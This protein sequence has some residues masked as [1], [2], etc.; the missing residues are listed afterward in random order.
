MHQVQGAQTLPLYLTKEHKEYFTTNEL[1]LGPARLS[2]KPLTERP[3]FNPFSSDNTTP[4][5]NF[6][7]SPEINGSK[8]DL[9]R[10][11]DEIIQ[12]EATYISNCSNLVIMYLGHLQHLQFEL[13]AA[14]HITKECILALVTIHQRLLDEMNNIRSKN[15]SIVDQCNQIAKSIAKSGIS[16]FW[17]SLYCTHYD[18]LIP[19][20]PLAKSNSKN[21]PLMKSFLLGM[22]N[23]L[24]SQHAKHK[25][26]SFMSLCQRPVDRIVKYKLFIKGMMNTFIE[27][28]KDTFNLEKAYEL[29]SQQLSKIDDSR[30]SMNANRQLNN[31]VN[32]ESLCDVDANFFGNPVSV[33][34]ASVIYVKNSKPEMNHSPIV[35]Y[36]AHLVILEYNQVINRHSMGKYKPKFIIPLL[37]TSMVKEFRY[38]LHVNLSTNIKL[39]FRSSSNQYQVVL[40]FVSQKEHDFWSIKFDLL[41]NVTHQGSCEYKL[42]TDH[43]FCHTPKN[44]TSCWKDEYDDPEDTLHFT[45]SQ[46]SLQVKI[47]FDLYLKNRIQVKLGELASGSKHTVTLWFIDVYNNERHFKQIASKEIPFYTCNRATQT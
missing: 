12:T 35:L 4:E 37:N 8:E 39:Q 26:L 25:D 44:L 5:A 29:V 43:L 42:D 14:V 22:K 46:I 30:I 1:T 21:V 23:F 38:G 19:I 7:F 20:E 47:R 16:V 33:G 15:Q 3:P 34:F 11:V 9:V 24:E 27:L 6:K 45:A 18:R 32:F 40:C 31:L 10:R 2:A 36:K 17:Y 13:P 28:G 41:I